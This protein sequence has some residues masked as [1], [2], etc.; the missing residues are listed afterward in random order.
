MS[1]TIIKAP[2]G[3]DLIRVKSKSQD[4]EANKCYFRTVN[5]S[6]FCGRPTPHGYR[7]HGKYWCLRKMFGEEVL[8]HFEKAF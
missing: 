8:F 2:D 7:G 6:M 4:E 1:N 5:K 3:T